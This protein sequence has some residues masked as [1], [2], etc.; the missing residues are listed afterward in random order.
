MGF[1]GIS[2]APLTTMKQLRLRIG[3]AMMDLLLGLLEGNRPDCNEVL[4]R[5]E[6]IVRHSVTPN[7]Q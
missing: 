6:L 1:D 3:Q 2:F 4:L 5:S 7:S